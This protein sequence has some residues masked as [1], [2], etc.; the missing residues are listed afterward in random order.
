MVCRL[1]LED[2]GKVEEL[3]KLFPNCHPRPVGLSGL[4]ISLNHLSNVVFESTDDSAVSVE[5]IM[6]ATM[7]EVSDVKI[8][9]AYR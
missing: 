5:Q 4:R 2:T 9:S 6:H 8:D 3:R 1:H 7:M